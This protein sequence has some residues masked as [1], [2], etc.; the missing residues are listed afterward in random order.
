MVAVPPGLDFADHVGIVVGILAGG[1][2]VGASVT[3]QPHW[4]IAF[5]FASVSI[6]C[7]DVAYAA[8]VLF[9]YPW[10]W[11]AGLGGTAW[12]VALSA[13]AYSARK[14]LEAEDRR[15]IALHADLRT[16]AREIFALGSAI[17][18]NI[19]ETRR[20]ATVAAHEQYSALIRQ[21]AAIPRPTDDDIALSARRD[22]RQNVLPFVDDFFQRAEPYGARPRLQRSAYTDPLTNDDYYKIDA[23]LATAMNRIAKKS[24][25]PRQAHGPGIGD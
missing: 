16:R 17:C 21:G 11:C 4:R 22:Y 20:K 10:Q 3:T 15:A 6:C 12:V 1:I 5:G 24:G 7:A 9:G 19:H 2:G 25:L 18:F 23:D 13:L 8:N 14:Y